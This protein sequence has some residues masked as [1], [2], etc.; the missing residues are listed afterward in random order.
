MDPNFDRIRRRFSNVPGSRGFNA[1]RQRLYRSSNGKVL[2]VF[3]GISESLGY[4]CRTVR[5]VGIGVL[6][7]LATGVADTHGLKATVLVCGF[8]YLLLA[9]LMRSPRTS[10]DGVTPPP[11]P[12]PVPGSGDSPF[13]VGAV[14][15]PGPVAPGGMRPDFA[16]IDRQLDGLNRRIQRME[17]IVTDRQYDWERR[18]GS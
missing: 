3:S 10:V 12:A 1:F 6:V 4:R 14:P 11:M 15:Y 18:M 17:T 8:F 16:Q 13:H 2:G 9:L 7:L 5:W